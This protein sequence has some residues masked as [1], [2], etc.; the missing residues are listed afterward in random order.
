MSEGTGSS[1]Q[2][3]P[4]VELAALR[5]LIEEQAQELIQIQETLGQVVALCDLGEWADASAGT[6]SAPTI[7][8]SDLR[9]ALRAGAPGAGFSAPYRARGA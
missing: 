6:G 5:Q 9:R 1:E 2:V 8:V 3:A 4:I 7:L